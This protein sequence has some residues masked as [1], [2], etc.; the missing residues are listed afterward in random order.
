[1]DALRADFVFTR[2][3]LARI[4]IHYHED[5][6]E[7]KPK[8]DYLRSRLVARG[9]AAKGFVAQAAPPTVTLPRIKVRT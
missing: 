5:G 6:G 3:E 4:G 9:G 1:M 2:E 8:I 7:E